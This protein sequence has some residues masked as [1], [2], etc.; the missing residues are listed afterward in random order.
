[1]FYVFLF[2]T[3]FFVVAC[4]TGSKED[5]IKQASVIEEIN[6][7][8]PE[9]TTRIEYLKMIAGEIYDKHHALSIADSKL[10][11]KVYLIEFQSRHDVSAA[12]CAIAFNM[13]RADRL[14]KK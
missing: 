13:M 11:F 12:T 2:L 4:F 9:G 3:I 8:C 6:I 10:F 5:K 14:N 1:M 7:A